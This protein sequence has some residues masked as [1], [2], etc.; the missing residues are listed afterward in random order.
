MID[1]NFD[2]H[3][4]TRYSDGMPSVEQAIQ[5]GKAKNL[6]LI[7][8]TDHFTTS[9]KQS[10][11]D[12]INESNYEKYIKDIMHQRKVSNFKCLIG[13]EVDMESKWFDIIKIPYNNFEIILFEYVNSQ[14]SLE[15]IVE[16]KE[17]LD[18]KSILCLAHNF[19]FQTADIEK[20]ATIL[21]ENEIAFELNSSYLGSFDEG[22]I[23]RLKILKDNDIKFTLGSDAHDKERIGDVHR[24]LAILEKID[25]M[26]NLIDI[27]KINLKS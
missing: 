2:L 11:I 7:A 8:I 3:I 12:S 19:F 4:H 13:I 22:S 1:T 27:S 15:Q 21:S 16:L 14:T 26:N 24:S 20:F 23:Q 10:Y 5:V 9:W 18:L 17:K 6:S 25:G